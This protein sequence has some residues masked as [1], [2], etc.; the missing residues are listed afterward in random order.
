MRIK[1]FR[2]FREII[3]SIPFSP[4]DLDIVQDVGNRI[5]FKKLYDIYENT[6][7]DG[8]QEINRYIRASITQQYKLVHWIPPYLQTDPARYV[9]IRLLSVGIRDGFPDYR[10]DLLE[11]GYLW[12]LAGQ[13]GVEPD[14]IFGEIAEL[15]QSSLLSGFM[16]TG[17]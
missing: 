7:D 2:E 1:G 4:Y 14:R 10:D 9:R 12:T 16:K 17:K 11:L 15:T 3:D 8:R 6:E 13:N 5:L